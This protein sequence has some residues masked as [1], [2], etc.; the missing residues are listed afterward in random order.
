[1]GIFDGEVVFVVGAEEVICGMVMVMVPSMIII[2]VA[3]V[4]WRRCMV[5]VFRS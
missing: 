1:M 4:N 3:E 2:T 5:N